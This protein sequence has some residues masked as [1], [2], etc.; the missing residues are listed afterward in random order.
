MTVRKTL[1]ELSCAKYAWEQRAGHSRYD[2]TQ[3]ERFQQ[4][5]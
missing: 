5:G 1:Y 4:Q 2:G 3:A